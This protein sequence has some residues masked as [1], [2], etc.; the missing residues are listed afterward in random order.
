ML[1]VGSPIPVPDYDPLTQIFLPT[2]KST[3]NL[4]ASSLKVPTLKRIIITSSVVAHVAPALGAPTTVTAASRV[5]LPGPYPTTFANLFEA[6]M[7]GK[8]FELNETDAF[9]E[10][11]KPHFSVAH[12]A[13]GYVFGH[14]EL[15]LSANDA[16]ANNSSNGILLST[17][18]GGEFHPI[19]GSYAHIDDVA[20][21]HLKVLGLEPS[22]DTP[23]AFGAATSVNYSVAFDHVEKAFP[24]A[25]ADGT[26]KRGVLPTLPLSF[27]SSETER[28][29]GIKLR[30][31]EDAVIDVVKQYLGKLSE[32]L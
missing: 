32:D 25:V 2:V 17:L 13:P 20:E 24:E 11:N 26:L 14:N 27:D 19:H 16:L 10:K 30:P 31:F 15:V 6:H 1:H 5:S 9:V 23:R 8:I 21:I 12:I 4:L 22:S 28:Y 3:A 7:L 29:L 18:T